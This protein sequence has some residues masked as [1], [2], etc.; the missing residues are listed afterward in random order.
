MNPR[1]LYAL[2]ERRLLVLLA[3]LIKDFAN[4]S[5]W[6]IW[7]DAY[8]APFLMYL[9]A[10]FF[11]PRLIFNLCT[12]CDNVFDEDKMK[13]EAKKLGSSTRFMAQWMRLWPQLMNDLGW[14][15][16]GILMCAVFIAAWQPLAIYLSVAMQFYDVIM[17]TIRVCIDFNRLNQLA[18]QYENFPSDQTLSLDARYRDLHP[19]YCQHLKTS[20]QREKWLLYL[21]LV[22]ASVLFL[23]VCL[24]LPFMVAIS[25]LL[26]IIGA[27]LAIIMTVINFEGR[28]Y[29]NRP[30]SKTLDHLLELGQPACP[31]TP[32][33]ASS[34][35]AFN[36]VRQYDAPLEQ[37]QVPQ[38]NIQPL[39]I[40]I[41]VRAQS[42]SNAPR[43][44]ATTTLAKSQSYQELKSLS[45]SSSPTGIAISH[46]MDDLDAYMEGGITFR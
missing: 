12:L 11:L 27:V 13:P 20:I 46:S 36:L 24:S 4:Y 6:I 21:A 19:L 15:I 7:A 40:P 42:S 32:S 18:E 17:A 29:L 26:P 41:L 38:Q 28:N 1:R 9:G 3:P 44:F 45:G 43:F 30:E 8:V 14:T 33:R 16:S 2:R 5:S 39:S 35:G 23:A 34:A 25:P 10:A 31:V 22:N 37:D